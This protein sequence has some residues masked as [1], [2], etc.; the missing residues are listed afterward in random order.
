[1]VN[2]RIALVYWYFLLG[3]SYDQECAATGMSRKYEIHDSPAYV[4]GDEYNQECLQTGHFDQH[5][6]RIDSRTYRIT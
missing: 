1:M 6:F 3:S 4:A 2:R 5:S